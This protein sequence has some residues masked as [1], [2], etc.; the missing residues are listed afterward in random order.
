MGPVKEKF[1]KKHSWIEKK[2]ALHWGL[3]DT[4]E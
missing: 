3:S 1:G 2:H 4:G